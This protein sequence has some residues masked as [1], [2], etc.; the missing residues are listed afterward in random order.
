MSNKFLY[1]VLNEIFKR[2]D[3]VIGQD[4]RNNFV[5]TLVANFTSGSTCRTLLYESKVV[6]EIGKT[7]DECGLQI[8]YFLKTS[9]NLVGAYKKVMFL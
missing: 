1:T 8:V 2:L 4:F 7:L 6:K 3:L 9:V 5:V